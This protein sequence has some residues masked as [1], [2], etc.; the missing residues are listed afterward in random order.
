M[1]QA[2]I[3]ATV[4]IWDLQVASARVAQTTKNRR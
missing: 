4:E 2:L 3:I 1:E